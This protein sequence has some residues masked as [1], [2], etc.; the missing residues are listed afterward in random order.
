VGRGRE[1][2]LDLRTE[3]LRDS[4]CGKYAEAEKEDR[5]HCESEIS[6]VSEMNESG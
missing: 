2:V 5:R 6:A 4:A 1:G 3:R